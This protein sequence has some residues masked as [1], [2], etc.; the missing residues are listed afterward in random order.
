MKEK[1][2]NQ[3]TK[4]EDYIFGGERMEYKYFWVKKYIKTDKIINDIIKE[5]FPEVKKYFIL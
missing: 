3:N 4:N 5:N 2:R 1:Y